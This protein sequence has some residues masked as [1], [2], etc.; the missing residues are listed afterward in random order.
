[1]DHEFELCV[2][3]DLKGAFTVVGDK[4]CHRVML[5]TVE[6]NDRAVQLHHLTQ[7]FSR[8]A[9]SVMLS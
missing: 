5:E 3:K 4:V 1:M 7:C 8:P 6:I 9:W 2:M